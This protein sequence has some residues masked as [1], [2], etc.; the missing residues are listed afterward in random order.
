MNI[1]IIAR[2]IYVAPEVSHNQLFVTQEGNDIRVKYE[3]YDPTGLVRNAYDDLFPAEWLV[4]GKLYALVEFWDGYTIIEHRAGTYD[5]IYGAHGSTHKATFAVAGDTFVVFTNTP[6]ALASNVDF[7]SGH[8]KFWETLRAKDVAYAKFEQN[9]KTKAELTAVLDANASIAAL[10]AQVDLL[11]KLVFSLFGTNNPAVEA[12]RTAIGDTSLLTLKS[13]DELIADVAARKS[14]VRSL[15]AKRAAKL[16]QIDADVASAKLA[17]AKAVAAQNKAAE[18][19]A[20]VVAAQAAAD[21]AAA[22][23]AEKL[24]KAEEVRAKV[25]VV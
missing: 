17:E 4:S 18:A 21:A 13:D 19:Q 20:A 3:V 6:V 25:K 24:A 10:E 14:K 23:A 12:L 8:A 15:Q 16:A 1:E 22:K 9:E 2:V 7:I 5:G 11:S